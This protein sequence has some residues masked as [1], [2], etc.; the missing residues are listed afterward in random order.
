MR[1][2]IDMQGAQTTGSRFRGIGRYTLSFAQAVARNRG[3]HEVFLALSGLFPDSIEPIRAAF[4]GLL[5][6]EN[7][8][9]WDAPAPVHDSD[10]ANRM[11]REAAE[12]IREAFLA[13]IKPD[14]I[15]VGSLFEG[16]VDDAVTSIGLFDH[17]TPVSVTL[18]DLIPFIHRDPYLQNPV[19]ER[20]Y[21]RKID[22]LR[23]AKLLLANS[24][25]SGREAIEHLGFDPAAVVPVGTDCDV[26]F[27]PVGLTEAQ[28]TKMLSAY[29]I[30]R[31]FVMYTGGIDYR[32]NIERLIQAYASLPL[33]LRR[34]YQLVVVCAIQPADRE[35]LLLVA[36][37]AGLQ[38]GELVLTG[39]VPD[40][41]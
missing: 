19:F 14:V 36:R 20:W 22:H 10:P 29:Q 27:R 7:I 32:K 11:R 12:R 13:S 4:D 17:T 6:Q 37:Q 16:F 38:P 26:R 34:Q 41:D 40:D 21:L 28:R 5:P 31:P 1:I 24:A 9:V 15:H 25:S 30:E 3:E 35:R 23:R 2:V 8:R 18:H 33:T 39:F